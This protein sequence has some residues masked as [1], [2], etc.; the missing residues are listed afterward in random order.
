MA[1]AQLILDLVLG[2]ATGALSLTL[3]VLF[4]IRGLHRIY[5]VFF[6]YWLLDALISTVPYLPLTIVGA[7]RIEVAYQVIE[8]VFYFLLVLELVDRIL[9]DHPGLAMLGRRVI[10]VVMVA[11][12]VAAI[13]T[14]KFDIAAQLT[15]PGNL[16]LLFQADRAVSACLLIFIVLINFFLWTFPVRLSRNTRAYCWGFTLFFLVTSIAPF[17]INT[18]APSFLDDANKIHLTGVFLCQ[19]IW[20]ITV[21]QSGVERK[22]PFPRGWSLAEQQ[23]VLSTLNAFEE[24]IS[25]THGR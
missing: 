16:R 20:L 6:C 4:L 3:A 12:T 11:A 19:L 5:P 22:P 2:T 23:K 15:L 24:Q 9:S 21:S 7:N 18:M 8:W 13:Y 10:Q 25:G 1:P 17:F 14:L